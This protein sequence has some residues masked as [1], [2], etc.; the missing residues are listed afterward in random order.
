[1]AAR[2]ILLGFF[3][4]FREFFFHVIVQNSVQ[5]VNDPLLVAFA[6]C[7]RMNPSSTRS[8]EGTGLSTQDALTSPLRKVY[9]V[10]TGEELE[11]VIKQ[12]GIGVEVFCDRT[13][14]SRY[15]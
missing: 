9:S 13:R 5:W 3:L 14:S 6:D 7:S 15:P 11:R 10:L 4:G 8:K 12:Y 1:M 2:I